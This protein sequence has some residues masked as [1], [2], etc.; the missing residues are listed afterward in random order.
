M[1]LLIDLADYLLFFLTS[2]ILSLGLL[3]YSYFKEYPY[4]Y[5]SLL[6]F[7]LPLACIGLFQ[8]LRQLYNYNG[9]NQL[10]YLFTWQ[11][12]VV[13]AFYAISYVLAIASLTFQT[14]SLFR[15]LVVSYAAEVVV[16]PFLSSLVLQRELFGH[17]ISAIFIAIGGYIVHDLALVNRNSIASKDES[18]L[19]TLD[20]PGWQ[21]PLLCL[22]SKFFYLLATTLS[23]RFI[24]T[25]AY[26]NKLKDAHLFRQSDRNGNNSN[27]PASQQQQ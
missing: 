24:L 26:F 22:L 25:K 16:M 13:A 18:S 7:S 20:Y 8:V 3:K 27:R 21:G 12:I 10:F 5:F 23:K 2:N 1:R 6:I 17:Y 15:F 19:T 9:R 14:M 4:P 11:C